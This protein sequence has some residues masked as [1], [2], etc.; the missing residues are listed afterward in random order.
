MTCRVWQNWKACANSCAPLAIPLA[1][2][3]QV[4]PSVFNAILAQ[5]A[6]S[7]SNELVNSVI[8]RSQSQAEYSPFNIGHFGLNLIKN[9]PISRLLSADMRI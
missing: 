7:D 9:M 6:E 4:K 3:S 1:K 2:G 8:L 5:T